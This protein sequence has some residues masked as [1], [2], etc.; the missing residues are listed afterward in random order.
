MAESMTALMIAV[1]AVSLLA[2]VVGESRATERQVE[3]KT[4]RTYAW[5]IMIKNDLSEIKVHDHVYQLRGT[6]CIY[7]TTE[8]ETYC[9]KK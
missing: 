7:D 4:D 2:L 6:K 5:H 9:V 3:L 8:K 1:I